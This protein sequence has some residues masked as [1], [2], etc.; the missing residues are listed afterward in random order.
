MTPD[1]WIDEL[2]DIYTSHGASLSPEKSQ[3][4]LDHIPGS[5]ELKDRLAQSSARLSFSA[6]DAALKDPNSLAQKLERLGREIVMPDGAIEVSNE[7]MGILHGE[8]FRRIDN[9][10]TFGD[11]TRLSEKLGAWLQTSVQKYG[12]SHRSFLNVIRTL[13]TFYREVDDLLPDHYDLVLTQV[14][15]NFRLEM[16]GCFFPAPGPYRI[17]F[18]QRVQAQ[19]ALFNQYAPDFDQENFFKYNPVL[20]RLKAGKSKLPSIV[21][22]VVCLVVAF[23]VPQQH[24]WGKIGFWVLMGIVLLCL[25]DL[26]RFIRRLIFG[27]RADR[28]Y[29]MDDLDIG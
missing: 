14:L 19:R 26:F 3:I 2:R 5:D 7:L 21:I 4:L 9:S 25:C 28:M 27:K 24:W 17:P 13:F 10:G 29:A 6:L 15:H 8:F 18:K 23:F 1:Q 20:N 16:K 11:V 22:L 12:N